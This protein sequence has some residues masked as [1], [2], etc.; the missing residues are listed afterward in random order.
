M[1]GPSAGVLQVERGSKW[2][3]GRP[4]AD[5]DDRVLARGGEI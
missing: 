4:G 3:G 5:R 1:I 2:R